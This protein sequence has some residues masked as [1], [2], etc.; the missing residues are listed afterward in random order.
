MVLKFLQTNFYF[1]SSTFHVEKSR[2]QKKQIKTFFVS[3]VIQSSKYPNCYHKT[4][5]NNYKLVSSILQSV[6][7]TFSPKG[8]LQKLSSKS[9]HVYKSVNAFLILKHTVKNTPRSI[10]TN[11]YDLIRLMKSY[12]DKINTYLVILPSKLLMNLGLFFQ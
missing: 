6:F 2:K 12:F 5:S 9:H 7:V 3:F 1:V 11:W 4:R 8:Y 10:W